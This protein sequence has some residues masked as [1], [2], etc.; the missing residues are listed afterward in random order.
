MTLGHTCMGITDH[1]YGL[2]IARGMSMDDVGAAAPR[3][4]RAQ[5]AARRARSASSRGSRRTSSPTARSICSRTSARLFEFVV[6]SP[7]SL[8]RQ[9]ARSD[10]RGCWRAVQQPGVAILGHPR[11]RMY[12]TRPGIVA[13]WPRMFARGR[14][15][16][17]RDRDRRQL[18]PAGH[19]LR[20]G[21]AGARRGLPVRARQRRALDRRAAVHR[22]R[23][24]ARPARRHPG[25]PRRSTAGATTRAARS[26]CAERHERS[27]RELRGSDLSA[28]VPCG[29]L[30][31]PRRQ[32][33]ADAAA[34]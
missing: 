2:P 16:R 15:A 23:D 29:S 12:N 30:I 18:A 5:R 20:A 14:D 17:R 3:D 8:L 27:T 26:G 24:R 1:S 31:V 4:R 28:C 21:G 33:V 11:G 13:D 6:A 10:A 7:H 22:L 32:R 34:R 9:D 19:R 25:G